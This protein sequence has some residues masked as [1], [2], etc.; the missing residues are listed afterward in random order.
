MEVTLSYDQQRVAFRPCGE[1]RAE[2]VPWADARSRFTRDFEDRATYMAQVM[3]RTTVSRT[4]RVAWRTV[5]RIVEHVVARLGPADR[6]EGLEYI[7]LDELSYRRHHEYITIVVD[8]VGGKV[9]WA[10]KGKN[11]ATFDTVFAA[12]GAERAAK[13]KSVTMDDMSGAYIESVQRGVSR[14]QVI[15]DRFHGAEARAGGRRRGATR[16]GPLACWRRRR[17]GA[18]ED[19]VGVVQEPLESLRRRT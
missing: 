1:I 8:H 12:L 5:G 2:L 19:Q 13:L 14:A 10:A 9:V 6:L 3:D 16:A 15:F 7:G 11:A 18:Q 17:Q 4:L